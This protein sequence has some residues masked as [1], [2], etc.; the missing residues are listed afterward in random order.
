MEGYIMNIKIN[1]VKFSPTK[2]LESFVEEKIKKLGQYSEDIIG[3]EI[4]LKLENTQNLENKVAEI[5]LE[6]PGNELFAKKQSKSF[7]ESTDSAIDALKKQITKHKQKRKA[8]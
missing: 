5:R 3:A 1:S 8:S 6:I 7:E 2:Q 4:F